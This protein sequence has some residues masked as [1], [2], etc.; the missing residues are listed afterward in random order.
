MTV[1][2]GDPDHA[3]ELAGTGAAR[4]SVDP[5]GTMHRLLRKPVAVVC[6]IWLGGITLA[7][8]AAPLLTRYGPLDQDLAA[9]MQG[10]SA[11]HLLGTD[12][13]GRDVLS[14]LLYGG[15]PTLLGVLEAVLVA[16]LIGVSFGVTAGYLGGWFDRVVGQ[17]VDLVLSMPVIVIL[18]AVLAV[19]PNSVLAP[20]VVLGVLGSAAI[21]RVVRSAT[22]AVREELYIEAARL[23]GLSH[24]LIMVRH[25][26]KR[27]VGP[28]I[29]Q[30][31]LFAAVAVVVQTGLSFL[32]LGV[33]P[34]DPSWGGMMRDAST[35]M[36]TDPWL[37]V[38]PGVVTAVTVLALGLLGDG[39]RDAAAEQWSQQSWTPSI[40]VA[41]P[42]DA[43]AQPDPDAA[44]SVRGLT[45]VAS[46]PHGG[47]TTL[48]DDVS[49]DLR[50]GE[51]LGIV[52]E[53]GCGKT[54]TALALLG[55]LPGGVRVEAGEVW[56]RG[57]KLPLHDDRAMSRK[58][59]AEIGMIFQEPA[60]SLDPAFRI[61]TQIGEVIQRHKGSSRR[62]ARARAVELLRTVKIRDPEDVARRYPHQI[63]GGMAQ[64]VCIA[65]ALA[66]GPKVLIA[67]E[68]T[69]AL[70]VTVQAD[71]LDLLETLQADTGMS[72]VLVTHDWGVVAE[73]CS[74]ALVFYSGQVVETGDMESL[75]ARPRHPYTANLLRANPYFAT[76]GQPLPTIPG[77]VATGG[78]GIVGCRFAPR[79]PLATDEC[80]EN[81]IE[82][83]SEDADRAYRCIHSDQLVVPSD[84]LVSKV[85]A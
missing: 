39:A 67:D 23:S 12:N 63:S 35:V 4:D 25:V 50:D 6:L 38:P 78:R 73:A 15:R 49:F 21:V 13:L 83:I 7:C 58:R 41:P 54:M 60:V 81:N 47:E 48:V 85:S 79:C 75:F 37:L 32:G 77:T 82:L 56:L 68:P 76:E 16:A 33:Q 43:A 3:A 31:S 30:V 74:R 66:A 61:D 71:I 11:E 69:T 19:Y 10:P 17:V 44:L 28:I 72:I 5:K 22:L 40:K 2:V 24:P 53:S 70:D 51:T 46:S 18:L 62:E 80:R 34:P 20:M 26:F 57:Q 29:V 8:L 59:G 36:S 52:G 84:R 55:L 45:V 42:A 1:T 14:R 27:V 64:R 9:A 65:R